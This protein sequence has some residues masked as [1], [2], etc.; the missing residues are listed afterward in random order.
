MY[1]SVERLTLALS[2]VHVCRQSC[3]HFVT[4]L[5]FC[6]HKEGKGAVAHPFLSQVR[7][8]ERGWRA[9]RRVP[10]SPR[11]RYSHFKQGDK[12]V[13]GQVFSGSR[14]WPP[15]SHVGHIKWTPGEFAEVQFHPKGVQIKCSEPPLRCAL[16]HKKEGALEEHFERVLLTQVKH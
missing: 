8:C 16:K 6:K 5:F 10:G 15:H 11:P 13:S 4:T 2:R 14:D 7:Q 1:T 3:F 12:E 9:K